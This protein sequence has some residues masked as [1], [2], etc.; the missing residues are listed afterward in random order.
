MDLWDQEAID[1]FGPTFIEFTDERGQFRLIAVDGWMALLSRR[2]DDDGLRLGSPLAAES[3]DEAPDAGVP[4]REAVIVDEVLP[5]RHAVA[6]P[7]EG[8][9]D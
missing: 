6:A 2:G 8:L 3:R 5:D 1:L 9:L 4:P 7:D